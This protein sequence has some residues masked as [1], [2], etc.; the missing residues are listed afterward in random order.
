MVD[1]S[2]ASAEKCTLSWKP[3]Y[4]YGTMS[5]Y[6]S[7]LWVGGLFRTTARGKA[8]MYHVTGP[9]ELRTVKR[10]MSYGRYISG[11]AFF[12]NM[13]LEDHVALS[14]CP[15]MDWMPR[16]ATPK[17]CRLEFHE[18]RISG[19][20][21][22]ID[23]QASSNVDKDPSPTASRTGFK[24]AAPIPSGLGSLAHESGL[25][26][27]PPRFFTAAFVGTTRE[28]VV[29]HQAKGGDP[30]DRIFTFRQ[31][32]LQ[33]DWGKTRDSVKFMLFGIDVICVVCV[34]FGLTKGLCDPPMGK[35]LFSH[36][37]LPG[38]GEQPPPP[39]PAGLGSLSGLG[40]SLSEWDGSEKE[41][42]LDDVEAQGVGEEDAQA[43]G[44]EEE[45]AEEE[46]VEALGV[47]DGTDGSEAEASHP[48]RQQ[49]RRLM[50]AGPAGRGPNGRPRR[51]G[52]VPRTAGKARRRL[53][54]F[55]LQSSA[56]HPDVN[57]KAAPGC[58]LEKIPVAKMLYPV[59]QVYIFLFIPPLLV[60]SGGVGL[61]EERSVV[62]KI[63]LCMGKQATKE[64]VAATLIGS[65]QHKAAPIPLGSAAC[66]RMIGSKTTIRQHNSHIRSSRASYKESPSP[67]R[68]VLLDCRS[69]GWQ[70]L[71]TQSSFCWPMSLAL[72]F[73]SREGSGSTR[74]FLESA[75]S[76][77]CQSTSRTGSA[78]GPR[79]TSTSLAPRFVWRRT[80]KDSTSSSAGEVFR[81]AFPGEILSRTTWHVC[82]PATTG[83]RY[84]RWVGA[85]T[86]LRR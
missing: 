35:P 39:A 37:I 19:G 83:L 3:D 73:C 9:G 71:H 64:L 70:S 56:P 48:I 33:T 10:R 54:P 59:T 50:F 57:A 22:Q 51:R 17:P 42:T 4:D 30:E 40:R 45:D 20:T 82:P 49:M 1:R 46:D 15:P 55:R 75:S 21:I 47:E 6:R 86:P 8:V 32:I 23:T 34:K 69:L 27:R 5:I 13:F 79:C 2:L 52:S 85:R 26:A 29:E 63:N 58:F 84:S 65:S 80:S 44:M 36:R 72:P 43:H 78:W 60:I 11:F 62:L 66:I 81:V 76:R 38:I 25:L 53:M 31:P 77:G 7:E 24:Y 18:V 61:F 68:D 14:R 28:H 12:K 16:G 74:A 41:A 67:Y